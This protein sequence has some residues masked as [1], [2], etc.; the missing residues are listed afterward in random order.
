MQIYHKLKALSK[1]VAPLAQNKQVLLGRGNKA[2][3]FSHHPKL[4]RDK[5]Q[6][7][8]CLIYTDTFS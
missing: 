4:K 3:I 8:E 2:F 6:P 1:F 5:N 7:D